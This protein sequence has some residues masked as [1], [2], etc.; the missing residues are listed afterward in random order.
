MAF[1]TTGPRIVPFLRTHMLLL[2]LIFMMMFTRVPKPKTLVKGMIVSV[3]ADGHIHTHCRHMCLVFTI[4]L[5]DLVLLVPGMRLILFPDYLFQLKLTFI[6]K[7]VLIFL[8]NTQ[9]I[10]NSCLKLTFILKFLFIFKL[11]LMPFFML[12]LLYLLILDNILDSAH[13]HVELFFLLTLVLTDS[14]ML[15]F[16]SM[17]LLTLILVVTISLVLTFILMLLRMFTPVTSFVLVHIGVEALACLQTVTFFKNIKLKIF[18]GLSVND[19][20]TGGTR[21]FARMILCHGGKLNTS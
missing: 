17:L 7:T 20:P 13:F 15:A 6:V 12:T 10:V 11:I 19:C 21:V 9:F 4:L 16:L 3:H 14:L 8:M 2:P 18:L 1:W 5:T